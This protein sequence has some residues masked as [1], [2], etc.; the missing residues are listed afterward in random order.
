MSFQD[1]ALKCQECGKDFTWTIA[2]QEEFQKRGFQNIPK[3]CLDCRKKR[4]DDRRSKRRYYVVT[5]SEC[6]KQAEVPF[7]PREGRPV[8]CDDC[9]KKHKN[10]TRPE[11]P[12]AA[13]PAAD[14]EPK[15][16]L[17]VVEQAIAEP[18]PTEIV[19]EAPAEEEKAKPKKSP[20]KKTEK[21]I[22]DASSKSKKATEEAK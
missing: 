16:E 20:R 15:P 9:F 2:E 1:Q 4:R 11:K 21:V 3:R 6:G 22:L 17:T 12:V 5:C 14:T 7:R 18:A 13:S 8:Y 10:D 19:P